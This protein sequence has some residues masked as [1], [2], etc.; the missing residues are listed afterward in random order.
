MRGEEEAKS[1]LVR[2][3][4]LAHL[5]SFLLVSRSAHKL[6]E[7]ASRAMVN[8]SLLPALSL[9]LVLASTSAHGA[10]FNSKAVKQL[11]GTNFKRTVQG[12]DVSPA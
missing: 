6:S 1:N 4:S 2:F 10:V 8:I 12:S 3:S 7:P 5:S 9:V 11:T